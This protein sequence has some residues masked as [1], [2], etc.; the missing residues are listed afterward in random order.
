MR[1]INN[2]NIMVSKAT[3][4]SPRAGRSTRHRALRAACPCQ[5]SHPPAWPR[6]PGICHHIN[7]LDHAVAAVPRR[8][9]RRRKGGAERSVSRARGPRGPA[10]PAGRL[11]RAAVCRT[12]NHCMERPYVDQNSQRP[13]PPP[14]VL[15]CD[16][17]WLEWPAMSSSSCFQT[18]ALIDSPR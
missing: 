6:S 2:N 17:E 15:L 1:N 5:P 4:A 10:G 18:L 3:L 12:N 8:R 14:A 16:C 9:R 13:V 11:S 7:Q